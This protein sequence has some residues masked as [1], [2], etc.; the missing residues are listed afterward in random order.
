MRKLLVEMHK[1]EVQNVS[2]GLNQIIA[3]I[4]WNNVGL[5]SEIIPMKWRSWVTWYLKM[6]IPIL[7]KKKFW[8]C[9]HY[10]IIS[11]FEIENH[12]DVK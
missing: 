12:F 11:H 10:K 5:S 9:T 7:V 8:I 4:C 1:Y 2:R 6:I 3:Y